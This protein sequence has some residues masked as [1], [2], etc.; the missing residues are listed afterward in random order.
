MKGA[1]VPSGYTEFRFWAAG[2][3]FSSTSYD[4]L[5]VNKG[6]SRAQ[7]KGSGTVNRALAPNGQP[8]KFMLWATD[9]GS[10]SLWTLWPAPSSPDTFRIKIWWEGVGGAENVVY[11]NGVDQKI[12]G[13]T[14]AV[15][16]GK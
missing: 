2:F 10:A 9:G 11:D 1:N 8:Y 4:W 3:Y 6:G 15:Y 7:Y 5:V 14:I 12:A 13:G 16:D